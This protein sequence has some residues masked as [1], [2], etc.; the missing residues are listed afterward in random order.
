MPIELS[1]TRVID[2]PLIDASGVENRKRWV[3][4]GLVLL[5]SFSPPIF[6]A[7]VAWLWPGADA[8]LW[9][10]VRYASGIMREITSLLLLMYV[11]ARQNR[12]LS[13]IGLRIRLNWSDP[14]IALGLAVAGTVWSAIQSGLISRGTLLL[15]GHHADMRHPDTTSGAPVLLLL[16]YGIL[17]GIFEETLV[18]GYLM[19]EMIALGKPV[20]LAAIASIALQTSYHLYYGF[21]G[22]LSISSVFI[23]FAIYFAFSRRLFPVILAHAF[24]D[25]FAMLYRV[26]H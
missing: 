12:S 20:W 21:A 5:I 16:S 11:L 17:A 1:Q 6:A 18:R 10:Y 15:F 8:N 14:L 9:S 19:T 3:D 24:L 26:H 25:I 22:A 2:L 23:V 7:T 13:S 4:L